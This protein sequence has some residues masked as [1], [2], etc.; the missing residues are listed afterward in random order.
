M[1]SLPAQ[2]RYIEEIKRYEKLVSEG[3]FQEVWK[4]IASSSIDWIVPFKTVFSGSF[5]KGN[6]QWFPDG[7]FNVSYNC[8]DRHDFK[9]PNNVAL[10]YEGDEPSY[11]TQVTYG[12]MLEKICQ[13]ANVM[14]SE[15]FAK[16]NVATIFMPTAPSSVYAML[17]CAR[18]GIVHNVVFGG[19]SAESLAKRI[20]DSKST[21]IFTIN[22]GKRGGKSIEMKNIVDEALVLVSQ[23]SSLTPKVFVFQHSKANVNMVD[24]R[25]FWIEPMMKKALPFCPCE[26]V[27]SEH[28]LFVMYTSG[29]TGNPKGLVHSSG[30]YLTY[31]SA[32]QKFIFNFGPGDKFGCAADIGW[33]TGHT[34][35]VYGPL[36]NGGPTLLFDSV[37]NYPSP[38]RYWEIIRRLQLTHFY[39]APTVVRMLKKFG[40]EPLKGYD[41]SSL[42]VLGSV[43]E[44]INDEAWLWF[45]KHI[46]KEKCHLVDT[47]WQ[48]ETGG[49]LISGYAGISQMKPSFSA[50]S[51]LG[52]PFKVVNDS[53]LE[54]G[55]KLI[56]TSPWPGMAKT[57]LNN[58]EFFISNYLSESGGY[59][60]GDAAIV[61]EESGFIRILGRIDDVIN[62][63]GHR[64]ST[65]EIESAICREPGCVEA[66]VIAKSDPITGSCIVAFVVCDN[67]VQVTEEAIKLSVRKHIGPIAVPKY[68]VLNNELPKTRS[69]KIVRRILRNI[70]EDSPLGDLSTVNNPACINEIKASL[71]K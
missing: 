54:Q 9:N 53:T 42:K 41:L 17:A 66:A 16:G 67:S 47:Y 1:I 22:E 23:A 18:L 10:L 14:R 20:V 37:P 71:N 58:H 50:G 6:C 21:L 48:S 34:Y 35:V 45:W 32:T 60:T 2:S 27:S 3:K 11:S 69:G 39:T 28:P 44:P 43:G 51:F 52:L 62:V 5:E 8:V 57:I 61:D 26:I 4:E 55:G 56:I 29:S 25:D 15:G 49:I 30:G 13:L 7:Y 33:I 38:S 19:F 65:A 12:E 46:G 40:L 24:G 63:S 36:A 68:I 31:A 59:L 64:L 70:V